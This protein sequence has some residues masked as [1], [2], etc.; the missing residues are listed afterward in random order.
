MLDRM[1]QVLPLHPVPE[2]D[3]VAP[4]LWKSL[5]TVA[6]KVCVPYPDGALAVVGDTITEIGCTTPLADLT[7]ARPAPQMSAPPVKDAPAEAGP[8]TVCSWFRAINLVFGSAGTK[9]VMV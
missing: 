9:S 7:A 8:A 1:P 2:S 4:R 5:L 6:V 3:Q